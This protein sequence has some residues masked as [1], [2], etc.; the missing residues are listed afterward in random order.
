MKTRFIASVAIYLSTS[1]AVQ[2]QDLDPYAGFGVGIFGLELK[3]PS[4]TQKNTVVGEYV[5]FGV[6]FNHFIAA[7]LR[8]GGTGT[9]TSSYSAGT[10]ITTALGTFPSPVSFNYSMKASYFASYLT[11]LRYEVAQNV[12]LYGLV[13]GTTI[14]VKGTFSVPGIKGTSG[15]TSGLSY[16][17]GAAY[18]F[19]ERLNA[20]AEWVQYWTDV[21]TGS[22]SKARVWGIVG[23][24][25]YNF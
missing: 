5:K 11:R 4:V 16:G 17:A 12:H 23:S 6:N 13:G 21:K 19:A 22:T 14:K 15:T 7:E 1:T 2:A 18:T 9:G 20:G 3:T 24:I 25:S 10:P 8:I